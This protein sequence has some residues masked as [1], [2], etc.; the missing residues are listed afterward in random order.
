MNHALRMNNDPSKIGPKQEDWVKSSF[1]YK[2][3]GFG[4][5]MINLQQGTNIRVAVTVNRKYFFV[6]LGKYNKTDSDC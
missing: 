5:V 4:Y 1:M 6:Y 3:G 2:E